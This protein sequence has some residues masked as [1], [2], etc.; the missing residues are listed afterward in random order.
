MSALGNRLTITFLARSQKT[1]SS[2]DLSRSL[3]PTKNLPSGENA[4]GARTSLGPGAFLPVA[5][6][7]K[8]TLHSLPLRLYAAAASLP[9]RDTIKSPT[10]YLSHGPRSENFKTGKLVSGTFSNSRSRL[11]FT[12]SQTSIRSKSAPSIN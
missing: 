6:S 5:V 7:H 10:V 9:S 11:P 8:Y 2:D 4:I 1:I 3:T 12:K